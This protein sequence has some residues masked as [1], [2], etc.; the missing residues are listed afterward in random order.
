[1]SAGLSIV[2]MGR[3]QRAAEALEYL[4]ARGHRVQ[5]VVSSEQGEDRPLEAA[6]RRNRV[7]VLDDEE[8]N[9]ALSRLS[10]PCDVVLS[11]LHRRKIRPALMEAPR[12]GCF[13]FH[14]APLP[15]LRG[16]GGYN[17]A[18]LENHSQ[19]G[20]SVHWVAVEID[21][22]DLVW[23]RR[24]PIEPRRETAWS[25]ERRA[26]AALWE[27]FVEFVDLLERGGP[28]PRL[29]QGEGRYISRRQMLA[30]MRIE[31]DDPPELVDRK[32]R[33]FWFPPHGGAYIERDGRRFTVAPELGLEQA[34]E[35]AAAKGR[36]S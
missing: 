29:P 10:R 12:V 15:E 32:A 16:V 9:A 7:A 2:L 24:F 21:T 3:K 26:Q 28:I 33:A 4:L 6:A 27:L 35:A 34:A 25:L 31:R 30:A 17:F 5:F 13:N 14:P 36:R 20:V 11:Y 23:V 19:Y 22:G 18:I 8:A 1:M